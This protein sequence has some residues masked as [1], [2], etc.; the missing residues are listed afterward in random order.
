M[1]NLENSSESFLGTVV[2]FLFLHGDVD[3]NFFKW[4][5][6]SCCIKKRSDLYPKAELEIDKDQADKV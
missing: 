1:V 6:F 3:I 5:D 2:A 4:F